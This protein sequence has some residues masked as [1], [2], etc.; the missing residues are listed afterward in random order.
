MGGGGAGGALGPRR[1]ER[2][3]ACGRVRLEIVEG[4][5]MGLSRRRG[6][7][8]MTRRDPKP[9]RLGLGAPERAACLPP[10]ECVSSPRKAV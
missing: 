1:G 8:L 5:E 7:G 3:A 4:G 10:A 9:T 2:R 6:L